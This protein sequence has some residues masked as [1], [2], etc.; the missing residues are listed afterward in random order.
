MHLGPRPTDIPVNSFSQP[1]GPAVDNWSPRPYPQGVVL[2]GRYCRVEPLGMH[3]VLDLARAFEAYPDSRWRTY[4]PITEGEDLRDVFAFNVGQSDPLH[5]AIISLDTGAAVGT[6]A[7]MS[8]KPEHGSMEMGWVMYSPQLVR[9]RAATEAQYLLMRYVFDQLGYRRYEWKCDSLNAPSK[10]AARRLGFIEEGTLRNAVVYK[11]R[12]RDTTYFS[13]TDQQWTGRRGFDGVR[14]GFERWLDPRN[15]HQGQ[16]RYSLA[17]MRAF[18]AVNCSI[19]Q[20]DWATAVAET[21]FQRVE[22]WWPFTTPV[23]QQD[24]VEQLISTLSDNTKQLVA[25]NI[26]GGDLAAGDRGVLHAEPDTQ[27][28]V[29]VLE[30]IHRA[31]GVRRFNLLLGRG[32]NQLSDA[33]R[34]AF[35][36]LANAVGHRFSGVVM[37]EPL[38]GLEDY[39]VTSLA[40]AQPLL[41]DHA[42][43][44]LDVYH[45]AAQGQSWEDITQALLGTDGGTEDSTEANTSE[46]STH[47]LDRVAHVQF[48]DA[49]GRG[50]PG[51][52]DLDWQSIVEDLRAWGYSGDIVLEHL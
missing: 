5:F 14:A 7:L 18:T 20:E 49:P 13:M 1:I 17:V 43:L 8:Q 41:G 3:H 16:Q 48:A 22:L 33:Q 29:D 35:T 34:D 25:L 12:S 26:Y 30:K 40:E 45:L 21:P 9:T 28:W 4:L 19:G 24:Q 23:P 47:L 32:G 44:L 31:T 6:V 42:G 37:V 15:F 51:T 39:P 11:G 38:S 27:G 52:G 2:H 50:A 46:P 36:A 10:A